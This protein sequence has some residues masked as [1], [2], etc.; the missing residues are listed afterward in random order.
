MQSSTVLRKAEF[1]QL[2]DE[3]PAPS[4]LGKGNC[5]NFEGNPA[6]GA[7]FGGFL[8]RAGFST[9]ALY[10]NFGVKLLLITGNNQQFVK[11]DYSFS[12]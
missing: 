1:Q 8:G 12:Q 7:C 4:K 2:N 3:N 10:K 11:I 5:V 9:K 6:S